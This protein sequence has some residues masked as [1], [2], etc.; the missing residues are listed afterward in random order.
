MARNK[1]VEFNSIEDMVN[2]VLNNPYNTNKWSLVDRSDQV[3]IDPEAGKAW[4][5]KW[6]ALEAVIGRELYFWYSEDELTPEEKKAVEDLKKLQPPRKP[7][8]LYALV[9]AGDFKHGYIHLGPELG[10]AIDAI[11]TKRKPY[12]GSSW[13]R[14]IGVMTITGILK[15]LGADKEVA[16]RIQEVKDRAEAHTRKVTRNYGRREISSSAK[17]L[18]EALSKAGER[19]LDQSAFDPWIQK[20]EELANLTEEE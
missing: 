11:W 5:E 15:R 8:T 10:S 1:S 12:E 7:V 4:E 9:E 3:Y 2:F 19:G 14:R 17:K 6:D 18:I 13:E 16:K 20:L